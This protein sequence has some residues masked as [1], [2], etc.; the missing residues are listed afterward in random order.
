MQFI[1][2]KTM[3][4]SYTIV[5]ILNSFAV[6]QRQSNNNHNKNNN[7]KEHKVSKLA[8]SLNS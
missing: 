3:T 5:D 6:K 4:C 2:N 7:N 8:P 1:R